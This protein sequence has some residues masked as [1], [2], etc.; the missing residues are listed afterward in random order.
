MAA[1]R[2]ASSLPSAKDML[3]VPDLKI[4][5]GTPC[6]GDVVTTAYLRT[7]IKLSA[8]ASSCRPSFAWDLQTIAISDLHKARNFLAARFMADP[9][10]T[11]LL[12]IDADMGFEPRLIGKMLQFDQ[13]FTAAL[14]PQRKID[15]GRMY[16]AS[17][18]L[19]DPKLAE[20]LALDFVSAAGVIGERRP[21]GRVAFHVDRGFVRIKSIGTGVMLL[22]RE[23][24]TT[25][26]EAHP[27]LLTLSN[28]SPYK[29]LGISDP[30]HQCFAAVQTVDNSFLS[31][32]V[33]FCH[34]W[35]RCGG[36]IWACVDEP[37]SH[38][39]QHVFHAAYIDRMRHDLM[40]S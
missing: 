12:F 6:S 25:L 11:H 14:Y 19:D 16:E 38:V 23:V 22:R 21:D 30:V 32:D 4:L 35:D 8:F 28:Q 18:R 15:M 13:P 33:S 37:V 31:E 29:E 7:I 1:Y 24:F 27:E 2:A 34:R 40:Q 39:G 20:C 3:A 26:R 10:Y 36:K 17:R 9:S 5:I